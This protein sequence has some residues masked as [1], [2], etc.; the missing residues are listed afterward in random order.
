MHTVQYRYSVNCKMLLSRNIDLKQKD[1][2]LYASKFYLFVSL[3]SPQTSSP[4]ARPTSLCF[5]FKPENWIHRKIFYHVF[6]FSTTVCSSCLNSSN[7]LPPSGRYAKSLLLTSRE[8]S[9]LRLARSKSSFC[10]SSSRTYFCSLSLIPLISD[11]SVSSSFIWENTA[12][13]IVTISFN[14]ASSNP[15]RGYILAFFAIAL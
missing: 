13:I 3:L 9:V 12:T 10:C 5:T 8:A 1:F 7:P 14:L 15:E 11:S 6:I 2:N 4:P